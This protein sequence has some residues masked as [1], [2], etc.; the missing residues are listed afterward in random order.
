MQYP[1]HIPPVKRVRLANAAELPRI[2]AAADGPL[3]FENLLQGELIDAGR[4]GGLANYLKPFNAA[5]ETVFFRLQP[6]AQGRIFYQD[7]FSGF[8]FSREQADFL[9]LLDALE[10]QLPAVDGCYVGSSSIDY[11]LPGLKSTLGLAVPADEPLISL[12]LG[13]KTRVAAHFD[14]PEN[15]ACVVAGR[16]RFT[17]FPP[18]QVA[19]LYPGPLEFTPAGQPISLVDFY[20]PD[21]HTFPRY[22]EALASAQVAELSAG[23][24]LYLPGM[25]WHQVEGLDGFNVLLNYWWRSTPVWT[26]LPQDAISHAL[27]TM[28]SLPAAERAAWAEVFNYYVVNRETTAAGMPERARGMLADLTPARARQLAAHLMQKLQRL[29]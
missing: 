26:G 11:F 13:G 23:D 4:A 28:G 29:L 21:F 24:A 10:R 15:L 5:R 19:N 1:A 14:L 27:L 20:Q 22:R 8:N 6:Q 7:D 3:V 2:I 18:D 12:W 16:R 25:W 9:G 17:L